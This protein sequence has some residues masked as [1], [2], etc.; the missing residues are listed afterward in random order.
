MPGHLEVDKGGPAADGD[1]DV[2]LL[3]Q[4]VVNDAA[5]VQCAQEPQRLPEIVRVRGLC[6]MHRCAVE[7]FARQPVVVRLYQPR[8]A[9]EAVE[10][11]QRSRFAAHQ[12]VR[13]PAQRQGRGR[14]VPDYLPLRA[15]GFEPNFAEQVLFEEP[16]LAHHGCGQ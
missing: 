13:Q 14:G 3:G 16:G 5:S 10:G 6:T 12:G 11:G 9:L 4:I 7:V 8:Y 2:G 15:A 1:E